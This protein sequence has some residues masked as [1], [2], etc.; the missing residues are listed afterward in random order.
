MKRPLAFFAFV[1]LAGFCACRG[2][3]PVAPPPTPPPGQTFVDVL[4]DQLKA[5]NYQPI[6]TR[7]GERVTVRVRIPSATDVLRAMCRPGGWPYADHVVRFDE[8]LRGL[9]QEGVRNISIQADTVTIPMQ[10]NEEGKC[11]TDVTDFK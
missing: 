9:R 11:V 8:T 5:I 1:T 4:A 3:Q 2:S 10:I 6:V 7:E